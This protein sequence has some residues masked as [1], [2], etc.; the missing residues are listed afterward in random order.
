VTFSTTPARPLWEWSELNP[1]TMEDHISQTIRR[2]ESTRHWSRWLLL[3]SV[4]VWAVAAIALSFANGL[5]IALGVGALALLIAALAVRDSHRQMIVRLAIH[6]DAYVIPEVARYGA[7]VAAPARLATLSDWLQEAVA[8]CGDRNTWYAEDRVLAY[9]QEIVTLAT[10]LG[11]PDA[12]V[13]PVSAVECQ[14]LLTHSVRSPLY[15]YELPPENL[16]AAIYRIR[17]GI[18]ATDGT[19]TAANER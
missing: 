7:R 12:S 11:A 3:D 15:N 10:E 13:S 8:S 18:S 2:L 17:A 1:A 16:R 6:G 9:R 19:R 5:A 4:A 14:Q